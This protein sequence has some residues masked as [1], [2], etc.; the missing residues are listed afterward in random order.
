[1]FASSFFQR[2]VARAFSHQRVFLAA[3]VV[4]VAFGVAQPASAQCI[5]SDASCESYTDDCPANQICVPDAGGNACL[6]IPD[7]A[8]CNVGV[9]FVCDPDVLNPVVPGQVIPFFTGV[10]PAGA[11]PCSFFGGQLRITLPDG[12]EVDVAG[13]PATPIVPFVDGTIP[14]GVTFGPF[15]YTVDAAD[16]DPPNTVGGDLDFAV[17]YGETANFPAQIPGMVL[18]I[19]AE[20]GNASGTCDRRLGLCE[21][22]L[23]KQISCD[24][25]ATFVDVTGADDNDPDNPANAF[26]CNGWNAFNGNDAENII[27]RYVIQNNSSAGTTLTGCVLTD[28]NTGILGGAGLPIADLAIG[29]SVTIDINV[30]CSDALDAMEP[31]TATIVCECHGANGQGDDVMDSD[32]ADFECLTP[33]LEIAKVCEDEPPLDGDNV[34]TVLV[35]NTGDAPLINCT[36]TDEIFLADDTCPAGPAGGTPI[37]LAPAGAF[38]LA[39]GASMQFTGTTGLLSAD[40]CNNVSVTCTID[41]TDKEISA[42]ADDLCDGIDCGDGVVNQAFETCD[43]PDFAPGVDCV[44]QCRAPNTTDECTCCGD[45]IIQTTSNETCDPPGSAA[46]NAGQV[47]RDD[48]TVCGDDNIDAGEFCDGAAE[49]AGVDCTD[50]C[51]DDCTCCGDGQLNGPAG[52]ESCDPPGSAAGNPG[53]ICRNDCSVCGDGEIDA[54]EFCDGTAQGKGVNCTLSCRDDCTC[55]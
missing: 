46:G 39:G 53:Q 32:T 54:G 24:G 50:A 38:N 49:A 5:V 55:C 25:G 47:C 1:M 18:E 6:A 22:E 13:Y 11:A 42:D 51:R 37:A 27:V 3:F 19:T 26:G 12:S 31:D 40:A 2:T 34:I 33:G 30:P 4:A 14:A 10:A 23:D 17:D 28:S 35:T 45:N 20:C 48:C 29:A 43:P 15:N 9:G 7:P 44:Q 16:S 21:V 36:V 52:E 41:E 8:G